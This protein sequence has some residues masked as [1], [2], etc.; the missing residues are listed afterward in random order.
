MAVQ[1]AFRSFSV[2]S[3][4]AVLNKSIKNPFTPYF[5]ILKV[6]LSYFV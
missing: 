5:C 6:E 3:E 2:E 4:N 1:A